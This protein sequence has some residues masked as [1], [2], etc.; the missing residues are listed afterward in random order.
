MS[1]LTQLGNKIQYTMHN[2]T[3]DPN[4]ELFAKKEQIEKEKAAE[5]AAAAEKTKE[6]AKIKAA[7]DAVAAKDDARA[8]AERERRQTFST[9]GAIGEAFGIAIKIFAVFIILG[10]CILGASLATNL[11]VYHSAPYRI[12]Y[13]IYGFFFFFLVV[14]YVLGYRW[15]LQ[16]KKPKFYALIPLVPYRFNH[17]LTAFLLSWMS[18]KPDNQIDLL[19]EWQRP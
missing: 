12:F 8:A 4:A 9:T 11:N 1:L 10:L 17:Q 15:W 13:A 3:Y 2:L 6:A 5:A 19:K 18:Y 14:P 7:A 16:G